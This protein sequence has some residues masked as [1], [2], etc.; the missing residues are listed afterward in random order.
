MSKGD[1]ILDAILKE[2][3]KIRIRILVGL[4]NA[5]STIELKARKYQKHPAFDLIFFGH[6][7]QSPF[8]AHQLCPDATHSTVGHNLEGDENTVEVGRSP[9]NIHSS[10]WR[11]KDAI[12]EV[13][14]PPNLKGSIDANL[15]TQ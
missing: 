10:P 2:K 5:K 4:R 11:D 7:T 15:Q 13:R 6:G 3:I 9:G 12:P 14:Y 1:P 8:L